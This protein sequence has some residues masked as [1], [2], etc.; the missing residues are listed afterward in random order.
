MIGDGSEAFCRLRRRFRSAVHDGALVSDRSNMVTRRGNR[1]DRGSTHETERG[2][3]PAAHAARIKI[4]RRFVPNA[5]FFRFTPLRGGVVSSHM[6]RIA[7]TRAT[8]PHVI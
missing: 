6:I 2:V 5:A 4:Q 1:R 7:T 3:D 8:I